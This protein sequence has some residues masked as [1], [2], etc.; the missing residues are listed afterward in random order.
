[1]LHHPMPISPPNL[2]QLLAT[3]LGYVRAKFAFEDAIRT[4][5]K[6]GASDGEIAHLIGYSVPMLE[7]VAGPP[8]PYGISLGVGT[9]TRT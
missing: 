4:A 8:R 1:M 9:P 7:A 2:D 6:A 5:R 3:S